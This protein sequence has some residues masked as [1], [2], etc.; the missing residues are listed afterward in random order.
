[1][2]SSEV[3]RT[4]VKSPPELWSELSDPDALGRHLGAL[5][6]IRITRT[7]PESLVEW[8]AQGASGSVEIKPSGWGTKVKLSVNRELTTPL[9]HATE[10]TGVSAEEPTVH[11]Q[12]A[13]ATAQDDDA[14]AQDDDASAQ[15]ADA[16]AQDTD[17][18]AQDTSETA[19][20]PS[21][22]MATSD[23][24]EPP[25]AGEG[26]PDA[27][28]AAFEA[29]EEPEAV[30]P[31]ATPLDALGQTIEIQ[32][33]M[34]GPETYAGDRMHHPED[35]PEDQELEAPDT[36]VPRRGFFARLFG[37]R[38]RSEPAPEASLEH[39][40]QTADPLDGQTGS[41]QWWPAADEQDPPVSE[42]ENYT[43]EQESA[44][45]EPPAASSAIESLQA[46]FTAM[47]PEPE[48]SAEP[49][50]EPPAEPES[51]ASADETPEPP[52]QPGADLA[53]ELAAAEEVAA[54]EVTAVLTA[55]LDRLGAA[56]HR[57][58][59]RS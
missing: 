21:L 43:P 42:Q 44:P 56:H 59:S 46:R 1:M 55:V 54:E 22:P 27:T 6:E 15:D 39:E 41:E 33:V 28:S 11:A 14:S 16:T 23:A 53:G 25:E 18:A 57:P 2:I 17:A 5:G 8:E 20:E 48:A 26:P 9:E 50:P 40:A 3:Q 12:H 29:D 52:A 35:Q 10:D 51:E 37:W 13:D 58:F 7:Q 38:R 47:E 49:E 31:P 32:A 30:E 45:A 36:L 34:L 24:G 4:L 19:P